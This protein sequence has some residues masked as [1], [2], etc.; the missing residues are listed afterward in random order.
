M[1]RVRWPSTMLRVSLSFNSGVEVEC[2]KVL[3]TVAWPVQFV[4]V[5]SQHR[6]YE[7][8]KSWRTRLRS[9]ILLFRRRTSDGKLW[10]SLRIENREH[11][12]VLSHASIVRR[13]ASFSKANVENIPGNIANDA[14]FAQFWQISRYRSK[15]GCRSHEKNC[16]R[17]GNHGSAIF[18][19]IFWR[20][21][22][23]IATIYHGLLIA[24][25]LKTSLLCPLFYE[26][27]NEDIS[28]CG[29]ENI[30]RLP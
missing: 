24:L 17:D 22:S 12:R 29:R 20:F 13:L 15:T 4:V 21:P 7:S 2:A 5:S 28:R 19:L 14:E 3:S 8:V 30:L 10:I 1:N 27:Q 9:S 26:M 11:Q 16:W 6:S 25:F 23:L 18:M